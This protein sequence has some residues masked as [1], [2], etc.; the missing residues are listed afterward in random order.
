MITG[1]S[2]RVGLLLLALLLAALVRWPTVP[3][4]SLVPIDPNTPLHMLVGWDLGHGGNLGQLASVGQPE[5]AAI[6]LLALPLVL[7]AAVLDLVV[8][9]GRA[10]FH[11]A[12]WLW[13][14]ATGI[15]MGLLARRLQ[16]TTVV[17]LIAVCTAPVTVQALGNGQFEN[18]AYVALALGLVAALDRRPGLAFAAGLLAGF[19]SPYQGIVL[20][21]LVAATRRWRCLGAATAGL[22][23]A[24]VYFV[25]VLQGV[26]P[27]NSPAPPMEGQGV[28]LLEIIGGPWLSESNSPGERTWMLF[29][30]PE[31]GSLG[32]TWTFVP[33]FTQ[34]FLGLG[35]LL[36]GGWGL[37]RERRRPEVLPLVVAGVACTLL[38][39]GRMLLLSPQLETGLPLPWALSSWLPGVGRMQATQRFLT[40]PTFALVLGA[41]W[42]LRGRWVAL[43]PL[44]IAEGLWL[45]PAHWPAPV[46]ALKPPTLE[47]PSE[48]TIALWPGPPSLP[49]RH[50]H[51]MALVLQRKTAWFQGPEGT[52][53]LH[54]PDRQ[55]HVEHV[56]QLD[57][58]GR[59][60]EQW[61]EQAGPAAVIEFRAAPDPLQERGLPLTLQVCDQN[62][63]LWMP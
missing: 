27:A 37:W 3:G 7:I 13:L 23:I 9:E 53:D 59:T 28:S 8:G 21:V 25:G 61:L 19:C 38:A 11:L 47:L 36:V 40:G 22:A 18:V 62:L 24:A 45:S 1:A 15:V 35:L 2:K 34:G 17:A 14:A 4:L 63:C 49:A 52:Q 46:R 50:H 30:G 56:I 44:L 58:H 41:A 48:G 43:V 31:Q 42:A 55:V 60:P 39:L 32:G 51:L 29:N 54:A 5:G 10:G 16:G 57:Q 26:D 6:R 20:F 33:T 12:V